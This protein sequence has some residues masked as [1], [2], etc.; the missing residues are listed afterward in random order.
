MDTLVAEMLTDSIDMAKIVFKKGFTGEIVLGNQ[1]NIFE[2]LP[3]H[4]SSTDF[5]IHLADSSEIMK[6]MELLKQ[7]ALQLAGSSQIDPE[8]LLIVSTS[9]SLTEMNESIRRSIREKKI[10]NNQLQQ[11]SQQ[12]EQAQ[13]QVNQLQQQLEQSTKQITR[14]NDKKLT[15]EQQDNQVRQ[16]I[17]W[18][19]AQTDR[20][21]KET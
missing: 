13:N 17:D 6:E 11:L 20:Q 9:K 5:D 3:E 4:Y 15:I 14:L 7:L 1:K 8:I 19:K 10:E 2:I 12:L 16:Q 21:F 18:F